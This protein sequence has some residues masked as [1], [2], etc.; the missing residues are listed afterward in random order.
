MLDSVRD[1]AGLVRD[2]GVIVGVPTI[3]VVGMR[4]YDLQTKALEQ[5]VKANEA[6]IHA[7]EAQNTV[8]KETQFDRAAALIKGQKDVYE[9]ERTA[10]LQQIGDLKNSGDQRVAALEEKLNQKTIAI[11][12]SD[13]A[14]KTLESTKNATVSYGISSGELATLTKTLAEHADTAA[15]TAL[16]G[17]TQE[18]ATKLAVTQGALEQFLRILGETGVPPE[19]L[20]EKLVEMASE[21]KRLKQSLDTLSLAEP[22][23]DEMISKAMENVDAGRFE[24][25]DLILK[26]A[27]EAQLAKLERAKT[28]MAMTL[29][30]RGE[31]AL[32]Q[33]K[34][35]EAADYF[36]QAAA[37]IPGD[38]PLEKERLLRRQTD[39]TK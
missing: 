9:A 30:R 14:I 22:D 31:I 15:A 25:A 13:V 28:S 1:V 24:V 27:E 21:Y 20:T 26:Q 29:E 33:T 16:S 37:L 2:I 35:R 17:K 3:I 4:L 19:H 8:L 18:L 5:Q 32:S 38:K 34:N 23:L 36:G 7:L 11:R 10:L 39:A 12:Q 6:Q